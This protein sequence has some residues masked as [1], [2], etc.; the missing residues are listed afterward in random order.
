MI[1]NLRGTN[2]SG[3]STVA[4][5]LMRR[6]KKTYAIELAKYQTPKGA[7]RCVTGY[8]VPDLDL[9]V[10]GRY[11]TACG[12]GDG[13]PT[14]Q[15]VK[16]SIMLATRKARNVFFEGVIIS[17]IFQGYYELATKLRARGHAFVW[18]YLDTPLEI[19]LARIQ[20][21]NGGEPI[22]EDLVANKV[23]AIASTRVKAMA[24]KEQVQ[25]VRY[26]NATKDV[27][28]ILRETK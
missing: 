24:A 12:G 11:E 1:V 27:L 7:P 4:F 15:L 2:G 6:D 5:D 16:D 17:T 10:V 14:Q 18:A 25:D 23:R 26:D 19:C 9:I 20:T 22:K 28:K 8:F 21:R 13:I 3:K